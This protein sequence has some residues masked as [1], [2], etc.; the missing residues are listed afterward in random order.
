MMSEPTYPGRLAPHP[1][2]QP[3][4]YFVWFV[5][6]PLSVWYLAHPPQSNWLFPELFPR[7]A[8][9]FEDSLFLIMFSTVALTG[10]SPRGLH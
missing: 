5:M 6:G 4:V 2:P 10:F 8:Y 1:A 7:G 3:T 9:L